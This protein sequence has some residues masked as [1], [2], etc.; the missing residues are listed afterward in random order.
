MLGFLLSLPKPPNPDLGSRRARNEGAGFGGFGCGEI[1]DRGRVGIWICI[2]S[3]E[4]EKRGGM[5]GREGE[6]EEE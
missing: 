1:E 4:G 2:K 3:G 5:V 6:E